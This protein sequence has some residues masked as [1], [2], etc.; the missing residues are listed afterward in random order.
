MAFR[1]FSA[2]CGSWKNA[3]SAAKLPPR[4]L[5][6]SGPGS[7]LQDRLQAATIHA[8]AF[9]LHF[10]SLHRLRN[11]LCWPCTSERKV[12]EWT[13]NTAVL[14]RLTPSLICQTRPSRTKSSHWPPPGSVDFNAQMRDPRIALIEVRRC[15]VPC[16]ACG[17]GRRIRACASFAANGRNS[18][19]WRNG[20]NCD[21]MRRS[22]PDRAG[23]R[24]RA[25]C[26]SRRTADRLAS[27]RP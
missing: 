6:R 1:R 8:V 15:P 22:K 24:R 21:I 9:D 14:R 4:E 7:D 23:V 25:A 12:A 11:V 26:W 19:G 10:A 5:P 2:T 16:G 13:W 17:R 3:G 20:P 18:R 27:R